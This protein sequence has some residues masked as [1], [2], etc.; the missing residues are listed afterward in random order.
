VRKDAS[1]SVVALDG[2]TFLMGSEGPE[3]YPADQ[4]G[5]V[6]SVDV[7]GFEIAAAAVTNEQFAEFVAATG[8][9]TDAERY[10]WSFV[11]FA[12]LPD[13][14]PPT[15][16]A[17]GAEWW[18]QVHGATWRTPLG[19]R[20]ATDEILEHPVVHV[21]WNDACEY[22]IWAGG[23]LPTEA[24][25]EFAARGGLEQCLYPW[26][27]LL[28]PDGRWRCNI[29]QG[30]FPVHNTEEDGYAGT[31]PVHAYEVNDFGIFNAVGNVWEWC[32]DPYRDA[33]SGLERGKSMRGG[34]Y[35]CHASYCNRYRVSAR[36]SNS[37][38]ASAGN[39]GIRVAWDLP[40]AGGL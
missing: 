12:F 14:F 17:V 6:R 19:P 21:S 11:F 4:E 36:S 8:Y 26:G 15:R 34:S 2:G 20:S 9:R 39:V 25:W 18:R 24:E 38:D 40:P 22:A 16:G 7:G 23:R 27:D 3:A 35:L 37:A 13:D 32:A 5:P 33:G 29:W 1:D 28:L 31:A 10:G 30:E